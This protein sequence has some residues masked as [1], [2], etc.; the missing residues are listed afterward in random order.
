MTRT[1]LMHA[2]PYYWT[3]H[4]PGFGGCGRGDE[5]DQAECPAER[6]RA[7]TG[8]TLPG[9][10][11]AAMRPLGHLRR[12]SRAAARAIAATT[13]ALDARRATDGA[14]DRFRRRFGRLG[15]RRG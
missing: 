6:L 8:T 15:R 2:R 3:R 5:H 14:L 12:A 7:G 1:R 10:A 13:A 9:R 11:R 4:E